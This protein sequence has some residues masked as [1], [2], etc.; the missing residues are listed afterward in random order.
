MPD[1]CAFVRLKVIHD[2]DLPC[3]QCGDQNMFDIQLEGRCSSRPL[4]NHGCPHALKRERSNK[5]GILANDSR[6]TLPLAR[7]PF[8]ARAYKGVKAMFEPHSSMNTSASV[9]SFLVSSRQVAR[10]SSLRSVA[11]KDFFFVSILAA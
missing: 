10:S 6:G 7:S 11:A 2:H 9:A 5:G 3:L 8:G 1:P 4:Q